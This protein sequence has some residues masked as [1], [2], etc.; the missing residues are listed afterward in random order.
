MYQNIGP[1]KV[2]KLI[3]TIMCH[4]PFDSF[5]GIVNFSCHLV[6]PENSLTEAA[7]TMLAVVMVL[8]A[9]GAKAKSPLRMAF[10]QVLLRL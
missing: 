7:F 4:A 3:I 1:K 6:A 5:L 2:M 9:P 8:A 10:E